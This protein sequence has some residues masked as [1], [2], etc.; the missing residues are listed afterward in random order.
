MVAGKALHQFGIERF[1]EA[2][3]GH[4]DGEA[5]ILEQ[6]CRGEAG[7]EPRAERQDCDVGALAHQPALA[8]GKRA[9]ESARSLAAA[10]RPL[11]LLPHGL[12]A[13]LE[14]GWAKTVAW[15]E[16][17]LVASPQPDAAR[18][19]LAAAGA[20]LA[21][22]ARE[23]EGTLRAE[24]ARLPQ[25]RAAGPG[26]IDPFERWGDVLCRAIEVEVFTAARGF[27]AHAR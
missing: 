5:A 4:A 27:I 24:L 1:E 12:D 25:A 8:E 3:I 20:R 7:L 21:E 13:E 23:A 11:V 16:P 26:L 2:G 10:T 9:G 15:M 17:V 22:A 19:A 6:G 18:F 14:A